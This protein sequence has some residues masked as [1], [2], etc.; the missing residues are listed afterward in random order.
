MLCTAIGADDARTLLDLW[1]EHDPDL[2]GIN[3]LRDTARTIAADWTR[4]TGGT[5]RLRTAMAMHSLTRG[6]RPAAARSGAAWSPPLDSDRDLALGWWDRLRRRDR[7]DRCRPGGPG[8]D[9]RLPHLSQ[10]HLFLWV[11]RGPARVRGA[12]NPP[13]AGVLRIGP[14]YTPPD[15]R[16]RGYASSAVAAVSRRGLDGG[17]HSLHA[18]HRPRQPDLEQDL[19]RR[20]LPA[21]RRV[22]G[23]QCSR[24]SAREV[25]KPSPSRSDA[26]PG[27]SHGQ[28]RRLLVPRPRSHHHRPLRCALRRGDRLARGL[29][30]SPMPWTAGVKR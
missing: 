10:G 19:R 28:P 18:L 22:G 9:R 24:A 1:L 20:R 30:R 13:V 11:R 6:R 16:G 21:Y 25:M 23:A 17:A 5:A 14:V 12:I 27:R 3:G 26:G 8:S 29:G 7:R 2:P 15:E 4:R